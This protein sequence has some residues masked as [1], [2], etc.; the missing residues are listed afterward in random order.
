M[1]TGR[2][3]HLESYRKTILDIIE[4]VLPHCTIYL[5][6]SRARGTHQAGADID[7]ALDTKKPIAQEKLRVIRELL[8]DSTMPL[9][10]DLVDMRTAQK[11]LIDEIK[12]EGIIWKK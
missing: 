9:M 10:V 5:F 12:K 3:E 6:G 7:L 2:N 11:A 4:K 8:E 1:I